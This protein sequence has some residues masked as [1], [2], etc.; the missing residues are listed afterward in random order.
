MNIFIFIVL[1][2]FYI[3]LFYLWL[4][5]Q[6]DYFNK[7]NEIYVSEIYYTCSMLT[8]LF[9]L[10][11]GIVLI[12]G[13]GTKLLKQVLGATGLFICIIN[14]VVYMKL[15]SEYITNNHSSALVVYGTSPAYKEKI[16]DVSVLRYIE[17]TII[18]GALLFI[19]STLIVVTSLYISE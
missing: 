14:T 15:R 10:L 1:H 6:Y 4:L 11:N 3:V 9:L 17:N 18:L 13:I 19:V 8:F 2:V 5:P 7:F 12:C 16:F